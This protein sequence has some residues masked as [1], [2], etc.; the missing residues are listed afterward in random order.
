MPHTLGLMNQVNN[1]MLTQNSKQY[2]IVAAPVRW[3]VAPCRFFA[4]C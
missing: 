1:I 2:F 3:A 4:V